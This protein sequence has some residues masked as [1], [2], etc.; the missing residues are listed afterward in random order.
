MIGIRKNL[1]R[2]AATNTRRIAAFFDI[3]GTLLAGPSLE[4]RFFAS[5]RYRRAIP[6][7][8]YPL[9]LAHSFRLAPGGIQT[10]LHANK[11][12]LRGVTTLTGT[13]TLACPNVS[14]VE[15][16]SVSPSHRLSFLHVALDQAA[17]HA[18]AN[19]AIILVSGT[20]APLAHRVALALA[21]RLLA[22]NFLA[23]VG[24]CATNLEE[25][26]Q[27]WT[28]RI[29]GD[30]MF[31]QAKA[32]A[33]RKIAA[34]QNLDLRRCYAYGD[35]FNDR[36]MLAAVGRPAAVNPSKKLE[37]V[38]R[39]NDWPVLRWKSHAPAPQ[40]QDGATE[41]CT[42]QQSVASCATKTHT[43]TETLV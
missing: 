42:P 29:L 26:D 27:C 20:L 8:N 38:A 32:R 5:L 10:V 16:E 18:A 30:A 35:S 4:R 25:I 11:M 41:A 3:D 33:I 24:V 36:W 34:D 15:S 37:R 40:A 19:H 2:T 21:L 1:A 39:L 31:G 13:G 43:A 6:A 28:G 7:R 23:Q 17:W 9:W 12:Y 14:A 22:R